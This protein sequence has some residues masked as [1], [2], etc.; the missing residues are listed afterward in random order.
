MIP[1]IVI[2]GVHE[3]P[4][5][6][7]T[8]L[9]HIVSIHEAGFEPGTGFQPG[10]DITRFRYP[11]TLHRFTFRDS[12]RADQPESPTASTMKRLLSI[13]AQTKGDDHVLFHCFAGKS[14]SAAAAFLFLVHHG[15]SHKDA[16]DHVLAVRSIATCPNLLMIQLADELMGHKHDMVKHVAMRSGRADWLNHPTISLNPIPTL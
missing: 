2:C 15:M 1:T 10:P 8:P 5:F 16:Y 4:S 7:D 14:R 11:F 3:V 9:D 6:A 12:D 13:F